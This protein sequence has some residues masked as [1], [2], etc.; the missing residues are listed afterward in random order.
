M[1]GFAFGISGMLA[2]L[3]GLADIFVPGTT[4]LIMGISILSS[5]MVMLILGFRWVFREMQEVGASQ[6]AHG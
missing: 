1:A 5:L 6:A 4:E 2:S 3:A